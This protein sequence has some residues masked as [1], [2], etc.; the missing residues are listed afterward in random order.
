MAR[1]E[2]IVHL[3]V[4]DDSQS[5]EVIG[6]TKTTVTQANGIKIKDALVNKN[7]SL[8]IT[9]ETTGDSTVIVK[10]GNNYPNKILGDKTITVKSGLTV[11][12]LEDISRFENRDG[13]IELDFATGFTGSI[14]ATAKRVGMKP[15]ETV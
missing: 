11:I 7:N 2:I 8:Q 12:L 5:V 9:V 6:F 1:D 3:P 13:S 4:Q 10:A 15:V 14:W